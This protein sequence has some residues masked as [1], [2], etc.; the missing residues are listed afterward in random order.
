MANSKTDSH[1]FNCQLLPAG[2]SQTIIDDRAAAT[3]VKIMSESGQFI[4]Y[5]NQ[6]VI[7]LLGETEPTQV[8]LE[9]P[10]DLIA[11]LRRYALVDENGRFQSDFTFCTH[12]TDP[13]KTWQSNILPR[14]GEIVLRTVIALDGDVIYQINRDFLQHPLCLGVTTAH[15]WLIQQLM[16]HLQG[17]AGSYVRQV[18]RAMP[19]AI[20]GTTTATNLIGMATHAMQDPLMA[21]QSIVLSSLSFALPLAER[22]ITAWVKLFIFRGLLNPKTLAGKIAQLVIGRI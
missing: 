17:N 19:I 13:I 12:Y 18:L 8:A 3:I 16:G 6:S 20:V 5:L 11:D 4:F 22:Q 7:S 9:M 14:S 15:H 2:S 10:P 21:M 1:T